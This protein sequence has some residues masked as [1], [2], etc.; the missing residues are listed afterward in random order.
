MVCNAEQAM[1]A[2]HYQYPHKGCLRS[3]ARVV[4]R[5]N[6]EYLNAACRNILSAHPEKLPQVIIAMGTPG[7]F[8]HHA[9]KVNAPSKVL[10]DKLVQKIRR[11]DLFVPGVTNVE[12]VKEFSEL[13]IERKMTIGGE[14]VVHEL[15]TADP[16]T[17]QVVFKTVSDDTFRGV[18]TNTMFEE[19]DDLY[20]DYTMNW[21]YLKGDGPDKQAEMQ[22]LI[23]NAVEHTKEVAEQAATEVAGK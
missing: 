19:G 7:P 23:E 3:R 5:Y 4:P 18:V 17:Q 12:V 13:S 14:K 1:H 8:V 10:W 6:G 21:M 22:K 9:V 20:L 16:L 11:P 2:E 15:I